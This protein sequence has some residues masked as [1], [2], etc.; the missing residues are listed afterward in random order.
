MKNASPWRTLASKVIFQNAWITLSQD[1]VT[2]PSGRPGTYTALEAKPFVIIVAIENE[3]VVMIE[4]YRYPIKKVILEFPAGGIGAG[5]EPLV[6]AQR[7]LKEE[8]GYEAVHWEYVGDFYEL[9]SISRQQG[10]L[11]IAHD[12]RPTDDHAMAE[13]GIKK[14]LLVSFKDLE[15]R[16]DQ[17]KVIDALTPAVFYKARL[18]LSSR[19]T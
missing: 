14:Q 17:G 19:L 1:D 11:F 15:R 9:V 13:D 4:Q 6:A 3:Q 5:E 12:L 7:E 8:T 16:I 10:H 2:T 18:R